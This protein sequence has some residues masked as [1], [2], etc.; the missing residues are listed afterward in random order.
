[1]A[2]TAPAAPLVADPTMDTSDHPTMRDANAEHQARLTGVE[3][4]CKRIADMTGA[5]LALMLSIVIQ[6]IWIT[7][8]VITKW[9][10]F[11]FAFLLT[12]SNVL[13]LILIFVI[14]VAE[15]QSSQH[16]EIRAETDHENIS[17]L[18]HHQEV[19]EQILLRVAERTQTDVEDIKAA[20]QALL[21]Q[22]QAAA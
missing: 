11:P 14:A 8:G 7:V 13:Q 21:V 2:T 3:K 6:A 19:Q 16:A 10:P 17:R 20:V 1:M 5:P 22:A 15:K 9:D 18:M 12:C 4:V